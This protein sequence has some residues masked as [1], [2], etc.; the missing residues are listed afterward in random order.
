[1]IG[2]N[3]H[4]TRVGTVFSCQSCYWRMS[5]GTARTNRLSTGKGR[6]VF[7]SAFFLDTTHA[8]FLA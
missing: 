5:L 2:V 7:K 1:M 4:S 3:G 8:I 6:G